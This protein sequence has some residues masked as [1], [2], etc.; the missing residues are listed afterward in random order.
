MST[1]N[2]RIAEEGLNAWNS[3]DPDLYIKNIADDYV[4]ESDMLPKPVHGA[5]ELKAVMNVYFNAFPD[6]HLEVEKAVATDDMTV[7]CWRATSTHKGEFLGV[8]A[9]NKPV[10]IRGCTVNE[11]RKGKIVKTTT[12]ADRMTLLGQFG[13][14]K[15]AAAS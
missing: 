11:L 12:Y 1:E 13:V 2:Q 9:T 6:L 3:Q 8:P 5:A 7:Q 15:A 14:L 10:T 4:W